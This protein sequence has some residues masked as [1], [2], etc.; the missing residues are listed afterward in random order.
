[1]IKENDLYNLGYKVKQD[2]TDNSIDFKP[3]NMG[4]RPYLVNLKVGCVTITH[5]YTS[6]NGTLFFKDSNSFKE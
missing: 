2:M 3:N 6:N 5:E 4:T 1:M